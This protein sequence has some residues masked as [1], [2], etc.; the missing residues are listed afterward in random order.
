MSGKKKQNFEKKTKL[1]G[2]ITKNRILKKEHFGFISYLHFY[3]SELSARLNLSVTVCICII[4][5][6]ER[7]SYFSRNARQ[8]RM[9][10]NLFRVSA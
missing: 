6:V 10:L 9:P 1:V 8:T 3:S 4:S 7:A 5:L 2:V